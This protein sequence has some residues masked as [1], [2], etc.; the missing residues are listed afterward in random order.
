[1]RLIV[2]NDYT[3]DLSSGETIIVSEFDPVHIPELKSDVVLKGCASI[4]A[5]VTRVSR[6]MLEDAKIGYDAPLMKRL[7]S[8]PV[9]C[10]M[11]VANPSCSMNDIKECSMAS[12]ACT[13]KN[14]KKSLGLFPECFA[15]LPEADDVNDDAASVGTAII[16][17]WRQNKYAIVVD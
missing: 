16:L 8:P 4:F 1:M 17:A 13:T 14:T 15:Y 9:I 3:L 6:E 12:D 2:P 5:K 10:L 7:G 11:R